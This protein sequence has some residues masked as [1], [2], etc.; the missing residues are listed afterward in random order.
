M[1]AGTI[2]NEEIEAA[3]APIADSV[4]GFSKSNRLRLD[5]YARGNKGWELTGQLPGGGELF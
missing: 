2:R 3:F 4:D 1:D 5:K